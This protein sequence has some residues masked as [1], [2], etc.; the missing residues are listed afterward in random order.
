MSATKAP[1]SA[2]TQLRHVARLRTVTA[3]EL[4]NQL[5]AVLGQKDFQGVAVTRHDRPEFVVLPAAIYE[6]L[7]NKTELSLASLDAEFDELIAR[8]NMPKAKKAYDS[9]FEPE[10]EKPIATTVVQSA[11]NG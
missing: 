6:N 11:S 9:L 7:M 2:K 10:Q 8:M 1:R 3:T 5:G 4:K